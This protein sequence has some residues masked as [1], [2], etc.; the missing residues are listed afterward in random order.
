VTAAGRPVAALEAALRE[1]GLLPDPHRSLPEPGPGRPWFVSALLGVSGWLAGLFALGFLAVVFRPEH[2]PGFAA[3][4]LA[5]LGVSLAVFRAAEGAF[6]AQGALAFSVAGHALLAAAAWDVT[7]SAAA[8]AGLVAAAQVAWIVLVPARLPRILSTLFAVAALSLAVRLLVGGDERHAWREDAV[9][10]GPAL[11]GW[12]VLWAP[13]A[14]AA[15]ALVRTEVRW[16]A[17]GLQGA[18]RPVLTG[19]LVALALVSPAS[20]PLDGLAL[21][22]GD[23]TRTSWLAL[24]PLLSLG[25]ALWALWLAHRVRSA[26]LAGTAVAGA[27]LHVLHF[28]LLLG[29]SLL[30]KAAVMVALGLALVAGALA[31]RRRGA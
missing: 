23:A 25:A 5:V 20:H 9:G 6:L 14:V 10:L 19:L 3:L 7:R 29:I 15:A 4:G 1:R 11:G 27:L 12:I 13:L 8:A 30:A 18:L 21:W 24:W 2:A 22:D 16:V 26:A 28:Y 31:L 17:R